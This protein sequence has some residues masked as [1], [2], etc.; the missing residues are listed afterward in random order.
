ARRGKVILREVFADLL[1]GEIL[2]RPKR[3]FG[4]PLGQWFRVQLRETMVDSIM[5]LRKLD[6]PIFR[7]EALVGLINDHL[8]G[9][10]DHTHRLWALLVLAR[11]FRQQ[12]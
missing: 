10:G 1:P 9:R 4:L 7:E 3:G 12:Q 2:W 8:L 5:D 6:R 11:W